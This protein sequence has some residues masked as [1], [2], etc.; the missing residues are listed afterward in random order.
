MNIF[1]VQKKN[2]EQKRIKDPNTYRYLDKNN[3]ATNRTLLPGTEEEKQENRNA[4]IMYSDKQEVQSVY[5][6][7]IE[8]K[9]LHVNTEK[10]KTNIPSKQFSEGFCY[11][12]K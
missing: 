10:C 9:Y 3:T 4:G 11:Y 8:T 7:L 6:L 5:K 1:R 12:L 2:G